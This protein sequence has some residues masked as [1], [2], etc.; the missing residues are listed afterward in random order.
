VRDE[1]AAVAPDFVMGRVQPYAD[2]VHRQFAQQDMIASL[3]W[4]FGAIGLVLAA[5]PNQACRA[6]TFGYERCPITPVRADHLETHCARI[7]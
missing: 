3:T 6:R 4:L 7:A 5:V 2:V 1:L